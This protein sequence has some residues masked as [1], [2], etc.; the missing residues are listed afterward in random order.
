MFL[1]VQHFFA[2]RCYAN[3]TWK[4]EEYVNMYTIFHNEPRDRKNARTKVS[5]QVSHAKL[6]V[7]S[8]CG[9]K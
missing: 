4:C 8:T 9:Q 6:S 7:N 3:G 1:D 2:V 5:A